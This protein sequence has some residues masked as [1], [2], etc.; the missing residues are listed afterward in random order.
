MMLILIIKIFFVSSYVNE[1]STHVASIYYLTTIVS[2]IVILLFGP[3]MSFRLKR[4]FKR[5]GYVDHQDRFFVD[6]LDVIR[7][8]KGNPKNPEQLNKCRLVFSY[9]VSIILLII[10]SIV[11]ALIIAYQTSIQAALPSP[12]ITLTNDQTDNTRQLQQQFNVFSTDLEF[13]YIIIIAL[14]T[15]IINALMEKALEGLTKFEGHFTFTALKKHFIL[16]S[17]IFKISNVSIVFFIRWLIQNHSSVLIGSPLYS[18]IATESLQK[19]EKVCGLSRDADQF[20]SILILEYIIVRFLSIFTP[21]M[22]LKMYKCCHPGDVRSTSDVGRPEFDVAEEY[23]D[24]LYRQFIIYMAIPIF[25]AVTFVAL[26]ANFLDYPLDKLKLL[27]ISK[28]PPHLSGSMRSYVVFFMTVTAVLSIII[29]PQG[30]LWVLIKVVYNDKN[31]QLSIFGTPL[32][33][34]STIS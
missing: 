31:C 28:T 32:I 5:L 16:K 1:P 34:N 4:H 18:F 13:F 20:F 30:Y 8:K 27:R 21:W 15:V 24:L 22:K 10:S 23:L 9:T 11:T 14:V 19:L 12:N 25:P 33:I 6:G 7:N 3:I 2:G 26:V 29:F 17:F